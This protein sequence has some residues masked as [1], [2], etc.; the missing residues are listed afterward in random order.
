MLASR[1]S[2]SAEIAAGA[3]QLVPPAR[4]ET[5][6]ARILD[7]RAGLRPTVGLKPRFRLASVLACWSR[8]LDGAVRPELVAAVS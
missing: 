7:W 8:A 5:W 3:E 1:T 4:P 6:A 2:P